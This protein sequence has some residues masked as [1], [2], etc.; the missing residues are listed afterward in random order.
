M[1][2]G[3]SDKEDIQ[4]FDAG[5]FKALIH[6]I[7]W[8]C[9]DPAKLGSTK[10]NKILWFSDARAD[11]LR[12]RSITGATYIR[13]KWGP[14]PQQI[15]P[16]RDQMVRDGLIGI[17]RQ[18]LFDHDQDV[19]TTEARPDLDLF[20]RDEMQIVDYWI[21]EVCE[22]HSAASVSKLSHDYT[23]EIARI[24]EVVPFHALRIDRV[25]RD[26]TDEQFDRLRSRA[27]DLGL[28]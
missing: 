8:R 6:Y 2:T 26:L 10:L 13:E 27:K 21:D 9:P 12:G 20:A 5:K 11:V 4:R 18:P 22:K 19:F 24:G 7:V 14:V 16:V 17:S 1:S 15:M 23:W 25:K 3:L 28:I